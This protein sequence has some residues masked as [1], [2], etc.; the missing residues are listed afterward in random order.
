MMRRTSRATDAND[1]HSE[2]ASYETQGKKD[3]SD[4]S[5]NK[6]STAVIICK[7]FH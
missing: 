6:N 7:C 2:E 5:E 3:Y 4:E 1:V